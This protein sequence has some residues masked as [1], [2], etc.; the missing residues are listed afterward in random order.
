MKLTI[1]DI[2]NI[3]SIKDE[4]SWMLNFRLNS[5]QYFISCDEPNFGPKL[6]IDYDLKT[7]CVAYF[8]DVIQDKTSGVGYK[9][10][11]K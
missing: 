5:Y 6:K 1:D 7:P 3:S 11:F 9:E 8:S 2:K 4:P 10:Y